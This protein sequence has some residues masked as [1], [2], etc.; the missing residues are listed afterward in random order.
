MLKLNHFRCILFRLQT[1]FWLLHHLSFFFFLSSSFFLSSFFFFF[2]FLFSFLSFFFS[3]FDRPESC[4][5]ILEPIFFF[6]WN[7]WELKR[8]GKKEKEM[9]EGEEKECERE[10]TLERILWYE[11][12]VCKQTFP[13]LFFFFLSS[14]LSPFLSLF[15]LSLILLRRQ[16]KKE[17]RE[18]KKERRDRKRN[19]IIDPWESESCNGMTFPLFLSPF[20]LF[21]RFFSF[22][23]CWERRESEKERENEQFFFPIQ[24][25]ARFFSIQFFL[26]QKCLEFHSF[27]LL[28]FFFSL[29]SFSLSLIV[30]HSKEKSRRKKKDVILFSWFIFEVSEKI[31]RKFI[32]T[33]KSQLFFLEFLKIDFSRNYPRNLTE[34]WF[35]LYQ[36]VHE[37]IPE[38]QFKFNFSGF[39][40]RNLFLPILKVEIY[41]NRFLPIFEPGFLGPLESAA[42]GN[43]GLTDQVAA[44]HWIQE[45]IVAF[46]GDPTNVTIAGHG[47]GAAL[48]HL[49]MLSPMSK[50]MYQYFILFAIFTLS[51]FFT[52]FL[53]IFFSV[54]FL[55]LFSWFFLSL[56][57]WFSFFFSAFAALSFSAFVLFP[58]LSFSSSHT[59]SLSFLWWAIKIIRRENF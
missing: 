35:F 42:R 46:G 51:L 57:S 26:V 28:S 38:M 56:F 33:E 48:V 5:E 11:L 7:E 13:F 25:S 23:L 34:I 18:R 41:I 19:S 39:L 1:T 12:D 20:F 4:L 58:S 14:F 37:I 21:L 2:L 22:F 8:V 54:F 27:Q 6:D 15:F 29:L 50:G 44:L 40:N 52:F 10:R 32:S 36:N 31:N 49:L 17:E 47:S 43:F 45:N 24:Y 55:S 9:N 16:R 53:S 30:F 59:H 3:F